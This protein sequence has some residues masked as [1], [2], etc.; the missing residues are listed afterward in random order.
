MCSG[1][2]RQPSEA[3]DDLRADHAGFEGRFRRSRRQS[4]FRRL[5]AAL[6]LTL[7]PFGSLAAIP[8]EL[9]ATY[10]FGARQ[11]DRFNRGVERFRSTLNTRVFSA[12]EAS[13]FVSV[14]SFEGFARFGELV[15]GSS[16][17]W[18][19]IA[20]GR[21][22]LPNIDITEFRSDGVVADLTWEFENF[23]YFLFTYH[24]QGD[25]FP[26]RLLDGWSWEAG[27]GFGFVPPAVWRQRGFLIGPGLLSSYD[28]KQTSRVSNMI[29]AE[30]SLRRRIGERAFF[31][32]G[33]RV[34][35]AFLGGWSGES[36][37]GEQ[38]RFY[39]LRNGG[40][41]PLSSFAAIG[42]PTQIFDPS[43]GLVQGILLDE[44]A[45]LPLGIV[46]WQF[47]LGLRF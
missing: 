47:S 39:R 32:T 25:E 4:K 22:D 16:Q 44:P 21:L 45:D 7:A 42:A 37:G 38:G 27:G 35:Y 23:S 24:Y 30:F 20:G 29:R 33:P 11:E 12:T 8:V 31:R 5:A 2:A 1:K 28:A 15:D 18:L 6:V 26:G 36:A 19:G 41:Y 46:E 3:R 43:V 13:P 17:H 14:P 10:A 9:G 34:S 40:F